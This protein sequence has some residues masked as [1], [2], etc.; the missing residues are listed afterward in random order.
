MGISK[1]L[2]GPEM[3]V[4]VGNWIEALDYTQPGLISKTGL[5]VIGFGRDNGSSSILTASFSGTE[6]QLF[7]DTLDTQV[8]P[9][10]QTIVNQIS[11]HM[12]SDLFT[13]F[14]LGGEYDFRDAQAIFFTDGRLVV[15]RYD[16][17]QRT[18]VRDELD[19]VSGAYTQISGAEIYA[20]NLNALV[21][22]ET[23]Q[24]LPQLRTENESGLT[25]VYYNDTV[26][27]QL[28]P[29]SET[30]KIA[31]GR[32]VGENFTFY[33]NSGT[34][35]L[36]PLGSGESEPRMIDLVSGQI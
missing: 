33:G 7:I 31:K 16:G 13:Q 2:Y 4:L 17:G 11:G 30:V 8:L 22:L 25:T 29:A 20:E 27:L 21:A 6:L 23:V 14:G 35:V 24:H 28:D 34:L 15:S 26:V 9:E 10:S 3:G 18:V 1:I 36:V 5:P 12:V 32:I 19:F